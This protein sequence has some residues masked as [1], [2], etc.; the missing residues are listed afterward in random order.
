VSQTIGR[1]GLRNSADDSAVP[2]QASIVVTGS[3]GRG[4]RRCT[5]VARRP[6]RTS[7]VE[8][9]ERAA[10]RRLVIDAREQRV[11]RRAQA[12]DRDRVARWNVARARR[13]PS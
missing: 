3:A 2:Q 8:L 11:K 10:R 4:V 1:G 9:L 13:A 5:R 12:L 7:I 6:W